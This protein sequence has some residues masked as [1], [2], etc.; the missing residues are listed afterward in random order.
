MVRDAGVH[1]MDF[2]QIA[3][4][5]MQDFADIVNY[6]DGHER[7]DCYITGYP[8]SMDLFKEYCKAV[9]DSMER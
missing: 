6:K 5:N 8:I 2:L 7:E 4:D 9:L 1:L 3:F